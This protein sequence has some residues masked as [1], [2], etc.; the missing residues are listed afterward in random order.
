MVGVLIWSD[1]SDDRDGGG[2][3]GA[4]PGECGR[5]KDLG[6]PM[7]DHN[8]LVLR[9]ERCPRPDVVGI[10]CLRPDLAAGQHAD[11]PGGNARGVQ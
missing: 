3:R 1:L 2:A 5:G 6:A 7:A 11:P 10:Q 9:P 4:G 8:H